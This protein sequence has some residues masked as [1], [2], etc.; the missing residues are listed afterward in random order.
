MELTPVEQ[1]YIDAIKAQGKAQQDADNE[2]ANHDKIAEDVG[3]GDRQAW[4]LEAA[5]ITLEKANKIL[6]A[7]QD[8]CAAKKKAKEAAD[9]AE[10]AA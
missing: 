1:A 2:K 6:K 5:K 7:C 9:K 3:N 4:Q 10:A 8:D